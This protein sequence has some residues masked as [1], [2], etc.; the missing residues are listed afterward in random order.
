VPQVS[1]M[2]SCSKSTKRR[3][4]SREQTQ[5]HGGRGFFYL[6]V[7]QGGLMEPMDRIYPLD[8]HDLKDA[9]RSLIQFQ[10]NV[11]KEPLSS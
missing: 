10:Y 7:G 4:D 1:S 3:R 8:W 11:G 9:A 5:A 2:L 6:V